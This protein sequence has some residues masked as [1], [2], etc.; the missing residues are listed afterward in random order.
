MRKLLSLILICGL[1]TLAGCSK[2][3]SQVEQTLRGEWK[4]DGA[5]FFVIFSENHTGFVYFKNRK[6][7]FA[8]V[9]LEDGRIKV[10]DP[11]GQ[12]FYLKFVDN[13]LRIE[14]TQSILS[15]IK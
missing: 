8:W 9:I 7:A 5:G 14:G 1:L 2:T 4:E 11:V 13:S 10:T 6:Q 12:V 3:P 15:K